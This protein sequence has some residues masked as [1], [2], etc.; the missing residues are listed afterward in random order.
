MALEQIV[1]T[2]SPDNCREVVTWLKARN[3]FAECNVCGGTGEYESEHGPKGCAACL[4]RLIAVKVLAGVRYIDYGDM[5][6][7]DGHK[8]MII[9]EGDDA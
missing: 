1:Y 9:N 5:V 3:L 7:W 6:A 4:S 8:V 2:E